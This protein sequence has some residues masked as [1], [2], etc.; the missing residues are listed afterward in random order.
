MSL[1]HKLLIVILLP[2]LILLTPFFLLQIILRDFFVIRPLRAAAEAGDAGAQY[3]LACRYAAGDGVAK[4]RAKAAQWF[5][6]AAEQWHP[7]A[8]RRFGDCCRQGLG[9]AQDDVQAAVW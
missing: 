4:D 5:G 3:D 7:G 2:L 9:V 1:L 6:K 8:Q